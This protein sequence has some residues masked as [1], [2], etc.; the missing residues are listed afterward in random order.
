[1]TEEALAARPCS[2]CDRPIDGCE[3][4]EDPGCRVP[5]CYRCLQVALGQAVPQP[6]THGG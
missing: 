1:M 2:R 6:H 5:I 4:C 3:L